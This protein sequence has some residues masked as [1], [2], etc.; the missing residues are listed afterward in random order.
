MALMLD[1]PLAYIDPG[2]GSLFQIVI[3]TLLAAPYVLRTRISRLYRAI[4]RRS[5][6]SPDDRDRDPRPEHD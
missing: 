6:V 4:R 5:S 3:A 2:S 1:V